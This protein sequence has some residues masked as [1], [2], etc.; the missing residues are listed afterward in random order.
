MRLSGIAAPP[1]LWPGCSGNDSDVA[2][3]GKQIAKYNVACP[4]V[5]KS[6]LTNLPA[7][8][9]P[10]VMP[11]EDEISK[12]AVTERQNIGLHQCTGGGEFTPDLLVVVK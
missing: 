2:K 11:A 3:T 4:E 1:E 8:A 9:R 10:I 12:A 7:V 5:M 6:R